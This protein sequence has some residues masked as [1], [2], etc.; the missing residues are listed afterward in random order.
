MPGWPTLTCP[1]KLPDLS[2]HYSLVAEVLKADPQM[3]ERLKDLNSTTGITL[4]KVIKPGID[5]KGHVLI[6]S[7]GLA[8]GDEDC[9][10]TF[11]TLIDGVITAGH[12]K[13]FETGFARSL[14]C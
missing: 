11:E 2:S 10:K 6:Q 7:S 9:Y 3:Y 4:A 1:D 12:A 14:D 5:V 8:A 13:C